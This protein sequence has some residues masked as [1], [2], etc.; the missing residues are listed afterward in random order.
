MRPLSSCHRWIDD[1]GIAIFPQENEMTLTYTIIAD[2]GIVV[3]AD[4]QVTHTHTVEGPQG[5]FSTAGVYSG[6]VNKIRTLKNGWRFHNRWKRRDSRGH[7]GETQRHGLDEGESFE[8]VAK[9]Y[10]DLFKREYHSKYPNSTGAPASSCF[11]DTPDQGKLATHKSSNCRI[12]LFSIGIQLPHARVM[13]LP[14]EKPMEESSTCI[15]GSIH[16]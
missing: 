9:A 13:D 8:D 10:C 6:A 16:H 5:H 12:R 3:G 7:A 1:G 15:I 14:G 2:G 11:A 4:S